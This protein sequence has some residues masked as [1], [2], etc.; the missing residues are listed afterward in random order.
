MGHSHAVGLR[1][2]WPDRP[3][4]KNLDGGNGPATAPNANMRLGKGE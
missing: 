1:R 3:E 4:I 2:A